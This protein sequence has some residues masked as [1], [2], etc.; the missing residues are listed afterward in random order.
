[1]K[2]LDTVESL[3]AGARGSI[4]LLRTVGFTKIRA[5]VYDVEKSYQ[6]ISTT[7]GVTKTRVFHYK[8]C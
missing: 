5:F 3:S 4:F 1:M 8:S 7:L 2:G 6:N